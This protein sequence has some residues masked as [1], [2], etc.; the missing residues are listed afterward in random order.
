MDAVYTMLLI[1]SWSRGSWETWIAPLY[2]LTQLSSLV[3]VLFE[4]LWFVV[5]LALIWR[6]TGRRLP[7]DPRPLFMGLGLAMH[8]ILWFLANLGPFSP[9][10]LSF[11]PLLYAG[12]DYRRWLQRRGGAEPDP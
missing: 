2:P 3:T 10:T 12:G 4:S 8:L 7:F 1:P 5:P 9:I 11:Y 6:A